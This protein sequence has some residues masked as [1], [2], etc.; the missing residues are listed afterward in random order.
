MEHFKCAQ[1]KGQ[2]VDNL[3]VCHDEIPIVEGYVKV[4]TKTFTAHSAPRPCN[5][6]FGLKVLTSEGIWI[7]LNPEAKKIPEPADLPAIEHVLHHEDL[8][9]GGIF[10]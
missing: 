9:D 6:H 3:E 5:K 1:K 7:E 2:L 4:P 10:T 8:L